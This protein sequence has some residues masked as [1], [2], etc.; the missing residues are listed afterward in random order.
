MTLPE[1]GQRRTASYLAA[2]PVCWMDHTP[3]FAQSKALLLEY[4]HSSA[5]RTRFCRC[6]HASIRPIWEVTPRS[7]PADSDRVTSNT[8]I[9]IL[10]R[11][12]RAVNFRIVH[13]QGIGGGG[14]PLDK[15][16]STITAAPASVLGRRGHF[17][18][19]RG[20]CFT[21]TDRMINLPPPVV[22]SGTFARSMAAAINSSTS[23]CVS[24]AADSR[25]TKR[26]CLPEP[27]SNLCGSGRRAP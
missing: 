16:H 4:C 23:E 5:Y 13:K 12:T 27:R 15:S 14:T 11:L 21:E 9:E 24:R 10:A 17:G 8:E 1:M 26:V 25:R 20:R 22:G 19:C 18:R 3:C 2:P 6:D 7:L